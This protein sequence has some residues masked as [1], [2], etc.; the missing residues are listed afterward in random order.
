MPSSC[1]VLKIN[2]KALEIL[3]ASN[4]KFSK[5][6]RMLTLLPAINFVHLSGVSL[7]GCTIKL[8][9]F[10]QTDFVCTCAKPAVYQ[11]QRDLA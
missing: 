3:S 5:T 7:S 6:L 11:V 2:F 4:A 9:G 8:P 1:F 10:K